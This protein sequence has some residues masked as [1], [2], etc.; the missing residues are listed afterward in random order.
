M[1]LPVCV[2]QVKFLAAPEGV[3]EPTPDVYDTGGPRGKG[4][5]ARAISRAKAGARV[6]ARDLVLGDEVL[7]LRLPVGGDEDLAG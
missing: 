6:R 2:V 7:L 3:S 1:S 4:V 5:A